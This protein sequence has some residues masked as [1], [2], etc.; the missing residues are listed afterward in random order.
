MTTTSTT[1]AIS[2]SFEMPTLTSR[3]RPNNP[4][5]C[6]IFVKMDD[7]YR[8]MFENLYEKNTILQLFTSK[9]IGVRYTLHNMVDALDKTIDEMM[10]IYKDFKFNV[11]IIKESPYAEELYEIFNNLK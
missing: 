6:P 4:E 11:C 1:S 5:E 7:K 2:F 8:D 10:G 9:Q 3:T